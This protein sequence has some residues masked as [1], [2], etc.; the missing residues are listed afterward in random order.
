MLNIV[1]ILALF[2]LVVGV[3]ITWHVRGLIDR[4]ERLEEA[5]KKELPYKAIDGLEDAMAI[6]YDVR[7]HGAGTDRA[8]DSIIA[9]I[10]HIKATRAYENERT[11]QV[12]DVLKTL[13]NSPHK[14]DTDAPNLRNSPHKYDTDAPNKKRAVA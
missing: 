8:F 7:Y 3:L 12:T 1:L 4:I 9:Q 10:N 11:E 5:A 13:R 14:Y 2:M 6:M